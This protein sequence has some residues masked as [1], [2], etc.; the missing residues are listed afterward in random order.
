MPMLGINFIE[1]LRRKNGLS[2]S[3]LLEYLMK[4]AIILAV[5]VVFASG[6]YAA[7]AEEPLPELIFDGGDMKVYKGNSFLKS[8]IVQIENHDHKIHP[9]IHVIFENQII[10]TI[11]LGHSHL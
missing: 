4:I 2:R 11:L 9:K 8:A 7:F 3:L 1:H 5:F 10:D 6:T